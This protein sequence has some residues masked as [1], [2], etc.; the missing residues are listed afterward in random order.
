[1]GGTLSRSL[2]AAV[3]FL[4]LTYIRLVSPQKPENAR[5]P[6]KRQPCNDQLGGSIAPGGGDIVGQVDPPSHTPSSSPPL[7]KI[8]AFCRDT[9]A[10]P[11]TSAAF[12]A[13]VGASPSG[14]VGAES[15]ERGAASSRIASERMVDFGGVPE[16]GPP[17]ERGGPP[18]RPLIFF[19][20]A[21]AGPRRLM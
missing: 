2:P 1:V 19:L 4:N 11:Q 16:Q 17:P 7:T 9:R 10:T 3:F 14:K 20:K 15:F 21:A 6:G 8:L 18:P 5:D 12:S 13:A